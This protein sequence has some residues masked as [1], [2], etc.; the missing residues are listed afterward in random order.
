MVETTAPTVVREEPAPCRIKLNVE[1]PQ[2]QV[3][4]TFTA[5][6][7]EF[8]RAARVPG[9]RP[10]KAPRALLMRHYG[11]RIN[12]EAKDR[13][14]RQALRQAL[15]Q[16]EMTPETSPVIEHEDRLKADPEQSFVFATEFDIA[17]TFELPEYKALE[18]E[19]ADVEIGDDQV[20]Q[21]VDQILSSRTSYETVERPAEAG[22]LLKA[23]YQADYE[24]SSE[25]GLAESAKYL[26]EANDT[27]LLLRE[28]EMLP[29]ISNKLLGV[30]AGSTQMVTIEFPEE[31]HEKSL[32]GKAL[33]Y[34]F[35]IAEIQAAVVP[36][37]ASVAEELGEETDEGVRERIRE[38]LASREKAQQQDALRQQLLEKLLSKVDFPIPPTMKS[39]ESYQIM[40][41]LYQNMAQEG[42][43]EEEMRE[44]SEEMHKQSEQIAEERL[45]RYFLLRNIADK[46]EIK[47]T[48]AEIDQMVQYLSYQHKMTPKALRK[49][50]EQSGGIIELYERIRENKTVEHLLS[51]AKVEGREEPGAEEAEVAS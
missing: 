4:Q 23:S 37:L 42:K 41:R 14:L 2:A 47:V 33:P 6:E 46:E 16:E 36:E 45:R 20:Q 9:F 15:Q 1:V 29:G 38:N 32:A 18:I 8:K 49:R 51:L 27:W 12:S 17:P 10:G 43:S 11:D 7:K 26:L 22:D 39:R 25:E 44:K 13:L 3:K 48:S 5:L 50:L 24:D 34:K 35:E 30:E 28:P 19:L 31:F 21:V 40:I